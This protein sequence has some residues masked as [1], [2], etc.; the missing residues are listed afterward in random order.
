MNSMQPA[1]AHAQ[2]KKAQGKHDTITP[3]SLPPSL[4]L[5]LKLLSITKAAATSS[6]PLVQSPALAGCRPQPSGHNLPATCLV[7][8]ATIPLPQGFVTAQLRVR[9]VT[10]FFL[11]A[12]LQPFESLSSINSAPKQCIL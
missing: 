6:E 8:L 1:A 9:P 10:P 4:P 5:C 11:S 7:I 12:T 3:P 2:H